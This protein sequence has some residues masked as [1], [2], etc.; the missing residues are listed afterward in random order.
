MK[1]ILGN[2]EQS[3]DLDRIL[4]INKVIEAI[5]TQYVIAGTLMGEDVTSGMDE[6]LI[7][8]LCINEG[9]Y[10][11]PSKERRTDENAWQQVIVKLEKRIDELNSQ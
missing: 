2:S 1:E 11:L 9:I 6:D 10:E 5:R 7:R 8:V 3:P 4:R